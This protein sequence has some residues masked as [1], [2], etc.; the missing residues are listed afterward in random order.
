MDDDKEAELAWRAGLLAGRE[1]LSSDTN[2]Y[3]TDSEQALDWDEAW[4]EG[5]RIRWRNQPHS[6]LSP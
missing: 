3:P 1:G 4:L 5:E 6:R 2:P